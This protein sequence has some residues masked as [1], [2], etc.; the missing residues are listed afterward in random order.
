M[1]NPLLGAQGLISILAC[2]RQPTGMCCLASCCGIP[3]SD[4]LQANVEGHVNIVGCRVVPDENIDPGSYGF[5]LLRG[6]KDVHFFSSDD[7]TVVRE[8]MKALLKPNIKRD[9]MSAFHFVTFSLDDHDLTR[10]HPE[11]IVFPA[12]LQVVSLE[13]AQAMNPRPPSPNSVVETQQALRRENSNKLPTREGG[14]L[15]KMQSMQALPLSHGQTD[16]ISGRPRSGSFTSGS[17]TK[18]SAPLSKSTE[19]KAPVRPPRDERRKGHH[20]H[21]EVCGLVSPL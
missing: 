10:A 18:S 3:S 13:I 20:W 14:T 4:S 7:Q 19:L 11:G 17:E 9:H 2:K 8:W 6:S 16:K 21:L 1:E 12:D 5:K 15:T